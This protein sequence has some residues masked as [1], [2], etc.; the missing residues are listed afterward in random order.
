MKALRYSWKRLKQ[1][2]VKCCFSS[3][4]MLSIKR[5]MKRKSFLNPGLEPHQALSACRRFCYSNGFTLYTSGWFRAPKNEASTPKRHGG[6]TTK[7]DWKTFARHCHRPKSR[8]GLPLSYGA[9][10]GNC[11]ARTKPEFFVFSAACS[12]AAEASGTPP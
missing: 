3:A 1:E 9:D 7:R 5:S 10:A 4:L 8:V 2:T 11:K 6:N 12:T